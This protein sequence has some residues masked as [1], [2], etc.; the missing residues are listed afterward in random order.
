MR[1]YGGV[2]GSFERVG[3]PPKPSKSKRA[4]KNKVVTIFGIELDEMVS[5]EPSREKLGNQ[6]SETANVLK[7]ISCVTWAKCRNY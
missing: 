3:L 5:L 2:W 4:D 1:R 6:L 7:N